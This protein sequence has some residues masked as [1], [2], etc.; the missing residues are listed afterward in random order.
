[1]EKTKCRIKPESVAEEAMTHQKTVHKKFIQ[2]LLTLLCSS[3]LPEELP[4]EAEL[5]NDPDFHKLYNYILALRELSAALHGGDLQRLVSGKG[6][7][8]ANLKALQSNLR[9]LSWQTKKVAE[10]DFSQKVDFLGEFSEAFNEMTARL[11]DTNS[12][13]V[14]LASEDT[15]TQVFNRLALDRFLSVAFAEARE[16]ER[17]L[18]VLLFDIDHFKKV[19][20]SFGHH[21]G[22]QVL[23]QI[24]QVLKKQFRSADMLARYGGEEFMAVLPETGT[25][26]AAVIGTR[27]LN[28]VRK[29]VVQM[30][31]AQTLSVTV[32]IGVSEIRTEDT[33]Y[34][35]LLKRCDRAL[36]EAKNSGRNRLCVL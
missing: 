9:H 26:Q 34:E 28:A 18:S 13:L 12:Q 1:M 19:N 31:A 3:R 11:C 7:I 20:D 15:L 6:F 5:R 29:A 24:S 17:A 36:Y 2:L 8:L 27:A 25:K 30:D 4:I 35:E 14:R 10:G 32:S 22:D 33:S 23:I 16:Q 21:A